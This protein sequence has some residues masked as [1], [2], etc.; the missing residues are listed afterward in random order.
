MVLEREEWWWPAT[1]Q[2]YRQNLDVGDKLEAFHGVKFTIGR[3]RPYK[4]VI[5]LATHR[6]ATSSS[7]IS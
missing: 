3:P 2:I 5:T 6:S 1:V 4:D 7:P